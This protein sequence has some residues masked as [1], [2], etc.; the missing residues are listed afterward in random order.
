MRILRS[1]G[2]A[3]MVV[4]ALALSGA[5]T[6][7]ADR[8]CVS[9]SALTDPCAA[10]DVVPSG[11]AL[12]LTNSGSAVFTASGGVI[13]PRITCT[14]SSLAATTTSAG[15][16]SGTPVTF[17]IASGG[18]SFSGCT[19]TGPAG[20]NA[21]AS[22]S[23][24]T[25]GSFTAGSS[26]DG[27]MG[28]DFPDV[29]F[30][31][32]IGSTTIV[33]VYGRARVIGSVLHGTLPNATITYTMQALLVFGNAACP[34]SITWTETYKLVRVGIRASGNVGITRN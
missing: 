23:S 13:N 7:S 33:C 19:S 29:S 16:S 1:L 22:S 32:P 5:S 4:L 21:S 15:G 14:T 9:T 34:R 26:F 12:S 18:L 6:A 17:S 28:F 11:T 25:T 24:A 10:G 2:L 30:T 20:C 31:C 27:S 8:L 3:A